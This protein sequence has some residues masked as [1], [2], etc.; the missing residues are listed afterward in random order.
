MKY[1]NRR[2]ENSKGEYDEKNVYGIN[3]RYLLKIKLKKENVKKSILFIMMNPAE[4]NDNKSDKTIQKVIN[5]VYE[6]KCNNKLL[7]DCKEINVVNAYVVYE[8]KPEKVN[9][10][11]KKYGESYICG[12]EDENKRNDEIIKAEIESNNIVIFACGKGNIR[13]YRNRI[14]DIKNI[15]RNSKKKVYRIGTLTKK[16]YPRHM[17]RINYKFDL[18]EMTL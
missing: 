15:L 10:L 7:E 13:N 12:N 2:V 18:E 1:D 17:S 4:A 8:P 9:K 3:R 5:Y 14:K 6:N 16:G 11:I